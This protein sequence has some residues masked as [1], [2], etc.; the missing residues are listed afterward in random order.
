[1]NGLTTLF[2]YRTDGHINISL[3]HEHI[4]ISSAR[5]FPVLNLNFILNIK[6]F[7]WDM[8]LSF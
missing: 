2:N 7:F 1:M 8:G 4:N 6:D 3:M 5:P